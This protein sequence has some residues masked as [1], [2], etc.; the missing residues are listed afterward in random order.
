[1]KKHRTRLLLI[2]LILLATLF[3]AHSASALE[4]TCPPGV[5]ASGALARGETELTVYSDTNKTEKIGKLKKGD[6]CQIIGISGAYYRI[7]FD[8]IDGYA[9]RSK[10]TPKGLQSDRAHPGNIVTDLALERL[11]L[12][13][14]YEYDPEVVQALESVLGRPVD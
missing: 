4:S 8:G 2:V 14:G 12:G 10:L 7:Q 11:H 6:T 1:M 9:L 5:V 13:L 3:F